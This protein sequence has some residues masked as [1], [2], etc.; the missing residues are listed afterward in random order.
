MPA[1]TIITV[2]KDDLVG[3]ERTL[4]SIKSQNTFQFEYLVIDGSIEATGLKVQQGTKSI[5]YC[6]Y[7][8]RQPAGIYDAMNFGV[9][10]ATGDY[11]LFLNAGDIFV[12]SFVVSDLLSKLIEHP[13]VDVFAFSV[14]YFTPQKFIYSINIPSIQDEKFALFHHQGVLMNRKTFN[15]LGGFNL[16]LELAADG[17]LLDRALQR[18]TVQTDDNIISAFDMTGVSGSRY[19]D[20]LK[21]INMYRIPSPYSIRVLLTVKNWLRAKLVS[22]RY[23]PSFLLLCYLSYRERKV[24]RR[25]PNLKD[26]DLNLLD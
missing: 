12:S 17:E 11:V 26:A 25:N 9:A 5:P 2:L 8:F 7:F 6:S 21:E 13:N 20:L 22:S 15:S 18:G 10:C 24:F 16:N 3:F 1:L 4:N 23:L 14:V 19:W